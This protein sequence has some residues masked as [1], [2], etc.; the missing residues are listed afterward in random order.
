[1]KLIIRTRVLVPFRSNLEGCVMVILGQK[2]E[3]DWL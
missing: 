3:T 2:W 1:M